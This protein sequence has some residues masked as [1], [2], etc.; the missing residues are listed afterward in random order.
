M[1]TVVKHNK[2]RDTIIIETAILY[3][4]TEFYLVLVRSKFHAVIYD[5]S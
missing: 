2:K 4:A 1:S 3:Y 5:V